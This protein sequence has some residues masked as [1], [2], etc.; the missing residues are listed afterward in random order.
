VSSRTSALYIVLTLGIAACGS[1]KEP[2]ATNVD[3]NRKPGQPIAVG[4]IDMA[5]G[6][7]VR[8]TDE[9]DANA[10][11][12]PDAPIPVGQANLD[13][14]L[15]TVAGPDGRLY[16]ID[17]NGHKIRVMD[18]DKTSLAF[19]VGT[20]IEGDAC[21]VTPTADGCPATSAELNH[22]A[23]LTFD[24]DGNMIIAAWHNAK[25]KR[26]DFR[27][28]TVRDM[29]G[30]GD[31]KFLGDGGPCRDSSGKDL[32]AFDLP[33]S[34]AFDQSSNL[35]VADQANQVIRRLDTSGMVKTVVGNCPST[36]GFGCP[37]GQGYAGDGG[38]ATQAKLNSTLGQSTDPQGKIA[39]DAAGNLYIAD[40]NNDII[41]KVVPGADGI[42][43]DGDPTEEIITT[44]AGTPGTGSYSG[45]GGPATEATLNH[46]TDF[47]IAADGSFYVA[48]RGN[49]CI[50]KID[51]SGVISTVAGRCGEPGFFG[52][53]G[54]AGDAQLNT[55][56]G[57][58]IVGQYLFVADTLN[59][60][61]RKVN[62]GP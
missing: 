28:N 30:T 20:G 47:A 24:S 46:P 57:V 52:D 9:V 39:F 12:V 48:D 25:I 62:L 26:L 40:T 53:G 11:G 13:T 16:I 4:N 10:D 60:C 54:P 23:D 55:P 43:G 45:D 21:E 18:A 38:P 15:D 59:N 42:V 5:A 31:R 50:R 14:P 51:S 58:N 34:V 27:A 61:I 6:T 36:P 8:A 1:S 29:C 3:P 22:P 41:R 35:F 33:S 7:A 19:V 2:T 49:S 32:V 37:L 17:W 44:I 56:Y